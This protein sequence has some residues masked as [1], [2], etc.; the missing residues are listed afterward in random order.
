MTL[1]KRLSFSIIIYRWFLAYDPYGWLGGNLI[2]RYNSKKKSSATTLRMLFSKWSIDSVQFTVRN[3][4]IC[5]YQTFPSVNQLRHELCDICAVLLKSKLPHIMFV[6][7]R[8]EKVSKH[9][10]IAVTIDC[11]I[12]NR[13][14]FK[15]AIV[16]I[17]HTVR[18]LCACVLSFRKRSIVSQMN[19]SGGRLCWS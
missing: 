1:C 9:S 3:V 19:Y 12:L 17:V 14:V 8:V 4:K 18:R 6:Q 16:F 13:I 7:L 11:N 10:S 15:E 5:G 2:W